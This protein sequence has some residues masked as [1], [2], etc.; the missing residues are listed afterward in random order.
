MMLVPNVLK[1]YV[2]ASFVATHGAK[3]N[4]SFPNKETPQGKG[5]SF[6]FILKRLHVRHKNM[7]TLLL[8]GNNS[9]VQDTESFVLVKAVPLGHFS[10]YCP[11]LDL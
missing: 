5:V 7:N 11:I 9:T 3:Y 4:T 2:K 10:P 6:D 8:V 1:C